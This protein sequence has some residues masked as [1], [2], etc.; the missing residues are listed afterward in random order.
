MKPAFLGRIVGIQLTIGIAA[1]ITISIGQ[2]SIPCTQVSV[3]WTLQFI[4][5]TG[6]S[7]VIAICLLVVVKLLWRHHRDGMSIKLELFSCVAAILAYC[8]IGLPIIVY[9]L[10]AYDV[11]KGTTQSLGNILGVITLWYP[12]WLSYQHIRKQ[13]AIAQQVQHVHTLAQLLAI[14]S[15]LTAFATF[16]SENFASEN[17]SCWLRV[18]ELKS[19]ITSPSIALIPSSPTAINHGGTVSPFSP[20]HQSPVVSTRPL[21]IDTKTP[22]LSGIVLVTC[23]STTLK[24]AYSIYRS[25]I[26]AGSPFEGTT[27][28]TYLSYAPIF[29]SVA[30]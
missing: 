4:I 30:C 8:L 20:R 18:R 7:A 9:G 13:R 2:G 26:V 12:L 3:W 24:N 1:L 23:L 14:P 21:T 6:F 22:V 25:F 17:L 5:G 28:T 11:E 27:H 29:I 10:E 15:A 16:L 19:A